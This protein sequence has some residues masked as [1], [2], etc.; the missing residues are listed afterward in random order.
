MHPTAARAGGGE[1]KMYT[2]YNVLFL[3]M[4]SHP[5][6]ALVP[7]LA[8]PLALLS[9]HFTAFP[10]A[11]TSA[12]L[13]NMTPRSPQDHSV[14]AP[15]PE[16]EPP[17]A[18]LPFGAPHPPRAPGNNPANIPGWVCA[19]PDVALP[20]GAQSAPRCPRAAFS[21]A[22]KRQ[23]V[24]GVDRAKRLFCVGIA[25]CTVL[26]KEAKLGFHDLPTALAACA[27][28]RRVRRL[29]PTTEMKCRQ[30]RQG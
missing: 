14:L 22:L 18:H 23:N 29:C 4:S 13:P 30:S 24:G 27:E 12:P 2:L 6:L 5:A 15:R 11:P 7:T 3:Y 9:Q 26:F 28:A 8:L 20:R 1:P 19:C 21:A 10:C 17:V 16:P 25:V